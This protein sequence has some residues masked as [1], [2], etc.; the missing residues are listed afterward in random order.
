MLHRTTACKQQETQ[1]NF[2]HLL[3]GLRRGSLLRDQQPRQWQSQR[4]NAPWLWRFPTWH[5]YCNAVVVASDNE[6]GLSSAKISWRILTVY[7]R[8]CH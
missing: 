3:L 5:N 6:N 1:S 8:P 4:L 2:Q 7:V